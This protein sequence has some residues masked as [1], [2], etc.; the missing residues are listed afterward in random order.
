MKVVDNTE[1]PLEE[2]NPSVDNQSEVVEEKRE[3]ILITDPMEKIAALQE[4]EVLS[5]LIGTTFFLPKIS[6][7]N[8]NKVLPKLNGSIQLSYFS[9]NEMEAWGKRVVELSERLGA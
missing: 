5:K 1:T 6:E 3:V 8:G 2:L 7:G 9:K 4:M